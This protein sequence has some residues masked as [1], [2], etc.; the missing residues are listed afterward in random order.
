MIGAE[1]HTHPQKKTNIAYSIQYNI[2]FLCVPRRGSMIVTWKSE[3]K[4][5]SV[6]ILKRFDGYLKKAATSRKEFHRAFLAGTPWTTSSDFPLFLW[7]AAV[8]QLL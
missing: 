6:N 7:L 5:L 2:V 3:L 4:L 1:S 8:R